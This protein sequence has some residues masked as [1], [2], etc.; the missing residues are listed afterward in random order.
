MPDNG[1]YRPSEKRGPIVND[2]RLRTVDIRLGR[3]QHFVMT[4]HIE[5]LDI[6]ADFTAVSRRMEKL[7][8]AS[9]GPGDCLRDI[10]A[11]PLGLFNK[12]AIVGGMVRDQAMGI[13]FR[14]DIDLVINAPDY[15]VAAAAAELGASANQF[16]GWTARRVGV[17]FDF[18]SLE[19][20]W[21]VKAGLVEASSIEEF[22]STTF[23]SHDA[24][25]FDL[26]T[27][28][29]FGKEDY[30]AGIWRRE[31]EINL[32]PTPIIGGNLYRAARRILLWDFHPGMRLQDFIERPLDE[33]TFE[34][35][36]EREARKR[37]RPVLAGFVSVDE[38]RIV[39]TRVRLLPVAQ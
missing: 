37:E 25:V 26:Q 11:G 8:G 32:L 38:L 34:M 18:W 31:I 6:A 24:I 2:T 22:P 14:S 21:A 20:T 12:T 23:F 1:F 9:G 35:M 36:V 33:A 29:V 4:H 5:P 30:M 27:G 19:S 13:P 7:I 10:M 15:E 39:L 28:R 3:S 16:G 17:D